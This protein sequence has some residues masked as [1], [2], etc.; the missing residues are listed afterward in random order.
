MIASS[1]RVSTG[2]KFLRDY[3]IGGSFGR[4]RLPFTFGFSAVLLMR[5]NPQAYEGPMWCRFGRGNIRHKHV[6]CVLIS[7]GYG[8]FGHSLTHFAVVYCTSHALL[9]PSSCAAN[10]ASHSSGQRRNWNSF[11]R[12][13]SLIWKSP[14]TLKRYA[15]AY[16]SVMSVA[17]RFR[18]LSAECWLV[19][20]AHILPGACQGDAM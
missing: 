11:W 16:S 17:P 5:R 14:W 8:W 18:I 7:C 19:A 3:I 1:V 15:R 12:S 9:I 10:N 2:A 20:L 13:L 6:L 4:Y